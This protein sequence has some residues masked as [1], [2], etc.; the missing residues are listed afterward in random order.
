M[1]SQAAQPVRPSPLEPGFEPVQPLPDLQRF[2]TQLKSSLAH[3]D[4]TTLHDQIDAFVGSHG[5]AL[6]AMLAERQQDA[7]G[8][9]L[10]DLYRQGYL[11]ARGSIPLDPISQ[12]PGG[13]CQLPDN[14]ARAP[15]TLRAAAL[16]HGLACQWL[17]HRAQCD[18]ILAR[19]FD[20]PTL[21]CT[22]FGL[23]R[24]IDAPIDSLKRKPDAA[25]AAVVYRGHVGFVRLSDSRGA[26]EPTAIAAAID[27]FIRRHQ[28]FPSS[29]PLVVTALDKPQAVA[30]RAELE[31][32]AGD[33]EVMR[34]TEQA[35]V[36]I[37]IDDR[38]PR[39]AT[40]AE[41]LRRTQ[42]GNGRNRWFGNFN[43]VVFWAHHFGTVFD[44]ALLDGDGIIAAA[45]ALCRRVTGRGLD[46]RRDADAAALLS[47]AELGSSSIH[48]ACAKPIEQYRSR[49]RAYSFG[50]LDLDLSAIDRRHGALLFLI[51]FQLAHLHR[52]GRLVDAYLPV[53]M[54]HY[55]FGRVAGARARFAEVSALAGALQ[56]GGAVTPSLEAC[57][58]RW[59]DLVAST[60]LD[61]GVDRHL[62]H[63]ATLASELAV[64]VPLFRHPRVRERLRYPEITTAIL[65]SERAVIDF[66][67][68]VSG[69]CWGLSAVIA[70]DQAR[71][72]AITATGDAGDVA[73]EI[74]RTFA[75]LRPHAACLTDTQPSGAPSQ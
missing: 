18:W 42:F 56:R 12:A 64:E 11:A 29:H 49:V 9:H 1:A 4:D 63:L 20:C 34:R 38:A 17:E 53:S 54:N 60:K 2:A 68:P 22:S 35:L 33:A 16:I 37:E 41:L 69:S 27:L 59:R 21:E 67:F 51:C 57:L 13:I 52:H 55:R 73:G 48:E 74:A 46:A 19:P 75:R 30:L 10:A 24:R 65:R 36:V 66:T 32:S 7:G 25:H 3:H 47:G 45:Q 40:R 5:A 43:L 58:R 71:I 50:T 72:V 44:H 61:G 70:P 6:H 23:F 62:T 26:I 15:L 28:A 31:R 14:L 39:D 8:R